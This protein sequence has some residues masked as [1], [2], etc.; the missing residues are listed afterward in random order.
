MG[1]K[2]TT[3]EKIRMAATIVLVNPSNLL[4]KNCGMVVNPIFRYLG[5][6]KMAAITRAI[7]EV[8]SQAITIN[9]LTYELPFIPIRCSEEILVSN[10]EPAITIPVKLLPPKK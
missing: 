1:S 9:P 6:K 7:E 5:T 8:T 10:M 3:K 2:V 4:S